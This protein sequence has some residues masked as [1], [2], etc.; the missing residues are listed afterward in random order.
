MFGLHR[1]LLAAAALLVCNAAGGATGDF[2]GEF[3][4]P[5]PEMRDRFG[6]SAAPVGDDLVLIGAPRA[7]DLAPDAGAAYLYHRDGT[8]VRSIYSPTPDE[9]DWFGSAVGAWGDYIV[10]GANRDDTWSDDA[11]SAYIYDMQ[12]RL[13]STLFSPNPQPFSNFGSQVAVAGNRIVV[14]AYRERVDD[15]VDAGAAYVFTPTGS[16]TSRLTSPRISESDLFGWSIAANENSIVIGATGDSLRGKG[17]GAVFEFGLDGS[18]TREIVSPSPAAGDNFGAAIEI[19][20]SRLYVSSPL[21]DTVGED[22]GSIFV[23]NDQ[24]ASVN[25]IGNPSAVAGD[26]FGSVISATPAGLAVAAPSFQDGFFASGAVQL[27]DA[28][29][30]FQTTVLNPDP[31][32]FSSFGTA[33]A[34]VGF[35]FVTTDPNANAGANSSGIAYLLSGP[36]PMLPGDANGDLRVNLSDFNALKSHF[37]GP[38]QR[39]QGDFTGDGAVSLDD[40]SILKGNFGAD[41]SQGVPE[42]GA[43]FLAAAALLAAATFFR[44]RA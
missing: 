12:G 14:T 23:F 28:A 38:G 20:G 11:G 29:G 36:Q 40:F 16:L 39:P 18:L 2:L 15:V 6:L 7:D 43:G 35:D 44:R 4:N 41:A 19:E 34:S 31:S 42:P 9:G 25:S 32:F 21:D 10:V 3:L 17:A 24:G 26:G 5:S 8:L 22:L 27:F 33:L 13:I 30:D 1:V 37:G